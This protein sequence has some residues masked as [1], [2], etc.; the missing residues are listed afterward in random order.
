MFRTSRT[1]HSAARRIVLM[2]SA[3]T[4]LLGG[5][6]L[7][8]SWGDTYGAQPSA[9]TTTQA[10][11]PAPSPTKPVLTPEQLEQRRLNDEAA[12][13]ESL[14]TE[15]QKFSQWLQANGPA[16][17]TPSPSERRDNLARYY[18]QAEATPASFDFLL[19]ELGVVRKFGI[20]DDGQRVMTWLDG[21]DR[22]TLALT[23]ILAQCN[24]DQER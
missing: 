4:L 1:N 2:C 11:T 24:T 23:D 14:N 17:S 7:G 20:S 13:Q 10:P 5:C 8:S 18:C 21:I 16:A 6:S 9:A 19:H 15:N 12:Y 3:G 22:E